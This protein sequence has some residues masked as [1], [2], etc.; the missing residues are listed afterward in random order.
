MTMRDVRLTIVACNHVGDG[1][2]GVVSCRGVCISYFVL[3]RAHS[4]TKLVSVPGG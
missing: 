4:L 1:G 3:A 2:D